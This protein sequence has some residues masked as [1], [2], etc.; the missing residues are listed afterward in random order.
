MSNTGWGSE[1]PTTT[2]PEA[3]AGWAKPVE[4]SPIQKRDRLLLEWQ[5]AQAV[6]AAAKE[7]E[8]SLRKACVE[9]GFGENVKE[10]MN[11]LDL[12]EGYTLKAG[13]KFNYKL[14]APEGYDG[15]AVDAV[16]DAIEAFG[17]ISNEGAFIAGRLFKFTVDMSISEYRD[18]CEKA[19]FEEVAKYNG[20]YTKMLA[21]LNKVLDIS[22]A[23]PSLEIKAPKA[24]K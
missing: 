12:G 13:V 14:K 2:L 17:R 3:M 22:E 24:K 19:K 20:P 10:G 8:M 1:G 5:Q 6:L 15:T 23:A 9:A 16:D 4:E 11:N 18:L 21:E 7:T